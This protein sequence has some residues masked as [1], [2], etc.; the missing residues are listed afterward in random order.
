MR[1]GIITFQRAYNY[2]AVLQA[3]ALCRSVNALG[4][5]CDVID[6][7][8][9]KFERDY[10]KVSIFKARNTREFVSAIVN[11]GV[12][13]KKRSSFIDFVDT[14]IQL[15]D[16]QYFDNNISETNNIYDIFITGSDQVWNLNLTNNDWHFFL[17]FV[18][19]DKKKLSYAASIV[20]VRSDN[21][22]EL[23]IKKMLSTFDHLTLRE[24][25]GIDYLMSLELDDIKLVLDPT[26]LLT[27]K[28][29]T[30]LADKYPINVM[31][32]EKYLLA[33]F[34]TP[35]QTNYEQMKSLSEEMNLPIV[36]IN[37]THRKV[38]GV[39]NLTTVSPGQF[40]KLF[41][42]A[43]MVI[44]NSFHGTVFSINLN[45]EFL[46]VLNV[47]KPEKNERIL[48]IVELL[49]LKNRDFR[50]ADININI[51][52]IDINLK[53]DSLRTQSLDILRSYIAE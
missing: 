29:W 20:A 38:E 33:Y 30:E 19:S 14:E 8:C 48:T 28:E 45:K 21:Q 51:N 41:L 17:D 24:K 7:H 50:I 26:L 43:S 3:Y 31:L 18:K 22:T 5:S 16:R 23:Q 9:S 52:W 42:N 15:S 25:S 10:R 40:I 12:R 53:L 44:T 11:G 39:V 4:Y 37:Y 35:T 49:G 27:Q 32:P 46:Y 6:Y 47:E 1:V 2:G 13:N 36:L 34:V